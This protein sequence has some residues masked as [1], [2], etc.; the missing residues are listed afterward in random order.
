MQAA[1][2]LGLIGGS[3]DGEGKSPFAYDRDYLRAI[4]LLAET[5]RE[6]GKSR[7]IYIQRLGIGLLKL[8]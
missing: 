5:E 3:R 1:A 6:E 8:M 7:I 4:A 2:V